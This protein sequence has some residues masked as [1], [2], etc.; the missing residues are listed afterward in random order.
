MRWLIIGI[1]DRRSAETHKHRFT[2]LSQSS[3]L[4]EAA[5]RLLGFDPKRV[6]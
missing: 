4:Q 3:P 5:F 6:Q 2:L 1:R